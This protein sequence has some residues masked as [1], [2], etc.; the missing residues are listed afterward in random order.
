VNWPIEQLDSAVRAA[1][2]QLNCNLTFPERPIQGARQTYHIQKEH[3]AYHG[4]LR[5]PLMNQ[6]FRDNLER[7]VALVD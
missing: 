2:S 7:H 4:P 6:M 5:Q 3:E 1:D